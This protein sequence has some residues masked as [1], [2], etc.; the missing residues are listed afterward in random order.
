MKTSEII[1][2]LIFAFITAF[3]QDAVKSNLSDKEI[4]DLTSKLSMKLLLNE[5]QKSSVSALLNTY[6]A[7]LSKLSSNGGQSGY[8]NKEELVASINS[9]ITALFDSKQKMKFDVLKKEWWESIHSAE[10]N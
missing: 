6:R 5:K 10:S 8:K 1:F 3:A 2:L 7:E 4:S 9:Q